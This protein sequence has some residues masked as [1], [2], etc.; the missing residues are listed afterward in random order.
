MADPVLMSFKYFYVGTLIANPP[1]VGG[2]TLVR[3]PDTNRNITYTFTQP[4]EPCDGA[5]CEQEILRIDKNPDFCWTYDHVSLENVEQ[6]PGFFF[7]PVLT[8][9]TLKLHSLGNVDG[10]VFIFVRAFHRVARPRA[11]FVI[12]FKLA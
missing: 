4:A 1:I 12:D 9:E 5:K 7:R 6:A 8:G 11:R 2:T 3:A 10:R